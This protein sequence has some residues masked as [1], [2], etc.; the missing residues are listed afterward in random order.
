MS[1]FLGAHVPRVRME[2]ALAQLDLVGALEHAEGASLLGIAAMLAAGA[3]G[4]PARIDLSRLLAAQR[5]DWP[6]A[7]ETAWQ[8]L[9][10]RRLDAR[11]VPQRHEVEFAADFFRRGGE[12]AAAEASM[13]RFLAVHPANAEAWAALALLRPLP[14]AARSAFHKGNPPRQGLDAVIEALDADDQPSEGPWLLP[15]AWLVGACATAD[16]AAALDAERLHERP[17]PLP[18]SAEAFTFYLV[19]AE[20]FRQEHVGIPGA[21]VES[22]R[23]LQ[24]VSAP[25]FRRYLVRIG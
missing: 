2:A 22:R 19:E 4:A 7:L 15:Y 11:L 25:A 14:A 12:P 9:V 23:R 10:A 1:L 8:R 13:A 3:G 6:D 5:A 16:L 21:V 17:I 24:L 18:G 20:K